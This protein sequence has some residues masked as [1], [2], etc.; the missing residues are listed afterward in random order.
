[1]KFFKNHHVESACLA[2]LQKEKLGKIIRLQLPG[3]TRWGSHHTCLLSFVQSMKALQV[4][5][6]KIQFNY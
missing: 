3:N 6:N 1:M 4:F 2:R 5:N